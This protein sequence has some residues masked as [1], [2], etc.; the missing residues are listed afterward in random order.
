MRSI[1]NFFLRLGRILVFLVYYLKELVISSLFVAWDIITPKD[2]MKPG[3]VEVPVDLKSETAIISLAN[4]ISMTP[5]SL[6][7]DMTPDKKKIYIHVMYLY[8]KEEFIRK[9]KQQLERRIQKI[10][11]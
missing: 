4:L 6:T 3:I 1:L 10:F 2:Y 8:D 11:E 9:T 7:L 5:G